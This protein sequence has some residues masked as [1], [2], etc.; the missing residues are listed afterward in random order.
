MKL[1][2]KAIALSKIL[3]QAIDAIPAKSTEPSFLNFLFTVT[4]DSL[5]VLASDGTITM[6]TILPAK[7]G[8][9]QNIIDS[10]PGRVQVPAHLFLEIVR[11]LSGDV[12]TLSM[13]DSTVLSV[14]DNHTFYTL[15]TFNPNE[16]P[17][18]DMSFDESKALHIPAPDFVRLFQCTNFAVATRGAKQC[19]L[20]IN[21]RTEGQVLY[22]LATDAMRLAQRSLTL[23]VAFEPAIK[24][25]VPVKVLA[26]IVKLEG[27]KEVL[28]E[29]GDN[30]AIFKAGDTVFQTRLYN[31]EFPSP[32]RIRPASTPYVL[33]VNSDEF[34][35]ALD[36]VTLVTMGNLASIARLTCSKDGAELVASSQPFGSA[37]EHLDKFTFEGDLFDITFNVKFVADAVRAL[38]SPKISLA[39]AGEGK[40][41]MIKNDDPANFQIVTPIRT[42]M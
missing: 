34:L 39:F 3:N 25:T 13:A 20:G 15:N 38:A 33:T 40:L 4:K 21:I 18:I 12:V 35:A 32:D 2:V 37:K 11:K 7:V 22:F 29:P 41:F 36:R 10:E 9:E 26:M 24:F 17:D 27:I 5:E 8:K 31:G 1:T 6:K 14:S 28:V 23:P 42:N 30:K 19:F 16:Y